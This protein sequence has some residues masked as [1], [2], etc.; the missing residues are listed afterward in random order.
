MGWLKFSPCLLPSIYGLFDI[1]IYDDRWL[2]YDHR[3]LSLSGSS[4]H[5]SCYKLYVAKASK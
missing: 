1:V 2:I 5:F 4:P 3:N